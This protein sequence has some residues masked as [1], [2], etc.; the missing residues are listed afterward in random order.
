MKRDKQ[1]RAALSSYILIVLC[2]S[3][4]QMDERSLSWLMYVSVYSVS[5]RIWQPELT[6]ASFSLHYLQNWSL[7]KSV[8]VKSNTIIVF[9]WRENSKQ[10]EAA[11]SSRMLVRFSFSLLR[12]MSHL[13]MTQ[14]NNFLRPT[15]P[16]PIRSQ[17]QCI[18]QR[19]RSM[20]LIL[21]L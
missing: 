1:W 19:Q 16:D 10:T 13:S 20:I 2:H 7:A 12:D 9:C 8:P 17:W 18:S 6:Q 15:L 4:G 5:Y 14:L 21:F 11:E 3:T